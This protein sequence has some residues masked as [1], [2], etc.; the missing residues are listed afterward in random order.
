MA[1]VMVLLWMTCGTHL[2]QRIGPAMVIQDLIA[3]FIWPSS[4]P[5]SQLLLGPHTTMNYGPSVD[6]VWNPYQFRTR[7]DRAEPLHA[8]ILQDILKW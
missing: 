6:Q 1:W 2:V 8:W 3:I 7:E 4:G 5:H